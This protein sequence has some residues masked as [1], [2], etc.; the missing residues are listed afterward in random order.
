MARKRTTSPA[1][2]PSAAASR[3]GLTAERI[4]RLNRLLR[5]LDVPQKRETLT[6]RLRIDVRG[7]YRDLES[8]RQADIKVT[9]EDGR[10][11]LVGT[12]EAAVA[13]LPFP[14]P[15]LTCGEARILATGRTAVHRKLREQI[16]RLTT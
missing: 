13:S 16:E 7:F 5:L 2:T 15:R 14:D 3:G 11:T 4:L 6:R 12:V 1:P 9:L 8:L 10:Y